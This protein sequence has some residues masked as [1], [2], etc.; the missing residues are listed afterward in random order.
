MFFRKVFERITENKNDGKKNVVA[1]MLMLS[2]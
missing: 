2:I 1:V